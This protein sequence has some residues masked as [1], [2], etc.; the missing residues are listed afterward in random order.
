MSS[1][2]NLQELWTSLSEIWGWIPSPAKAVAGAAAGTLFGAWLTSRAQ[3]QREISDELRALRSAHS[4][5]LAIATKAVAWRR[6]QILPV[7]EAYDQTRQDF[8]LYAT[9]PRMVPFNARF[10]FHT[11]P[12]M[13]TPIAALEKLIFEKCE[14][15]PKAIGATSELR[16]AI[17]GLNSSLKMRNELIDEM[18]LATD[19]SDQ[20]RLF[21]Y[22]GLPDPTKQRVDQRYK[23]VIEALDS[24][25]KD[26]IFFARKLA[27]ECIRNANARTKKYW[28]YHL[29]YRR[30]DPADW[31]QVERKLLPDDSEYVAWLSGFKDVAPRRRWAKLRQFTT[32]VQAAVARK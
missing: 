31:R 24:Q 14:V 1:L 3:R 28:M 32:R 18:R 29:P 7:K 16:S 26:C 9:G 11:L 5:A 6:Q 30:L 4:L 19:L 8:E 22:L 2:H 15:G 27:D 21:R 10:E 23:N 17:E 12:E 20:V 13:Q 25:S